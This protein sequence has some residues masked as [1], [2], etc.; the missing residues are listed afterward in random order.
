MAVPDGSAESRFAE[1]LAVL[2][3]GW[4]LTV[5]E[6]SDERNY[7]PI[8]LL[9]LF[10]RTASRTGSTPPVPLSWAGD[11]P[12]DPESVAVSSA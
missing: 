2:P 9:E 4:P 3:K 5:A 6:F 11:R 1:V 8:R 10:D 12:A 7:W